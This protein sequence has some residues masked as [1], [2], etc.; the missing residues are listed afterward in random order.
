MLT[1]LSGRN[2]GGSDSDSDKIHRWGSDGRVRN[3]VD[4]IGAVG[5][6]GWGKRATAREDRV[7]KFRFGVRRLPTAVEQM[8]SEPIATYVLE[9]CH[10]C[11]RLFQK[12]SLGIMMS[13]RSRSSP[14]HLTGSTSTYINSTWIKERP[15]LTD[16]ADTGPL[17]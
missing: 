11:K 8:S 2:A 16:C 5:S 12:E 15:A 10:S 13:R 9:C 17:I 6:G 1:W 7:L 3:A 4:S 14:G